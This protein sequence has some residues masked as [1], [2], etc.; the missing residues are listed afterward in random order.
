MNDVSSRSHAIFQLMLTQTRTQ[1][2][3]A[4]TIRMERA[5]KINLVDLAGSERSGD[6]NADDT[7]R[8]K[9]GNL[10]NL[11]L[12]TLR[13]VMST[14]AQNPGAKGKHI[15]YRESVLTWLLRESLGGNAKTLMVAAVSPADCNY[16]ET[17][18]TVRYASQ[19]KSIT[20]KAVVNEDAGTVIVR[21]LNE[22]I[23][24]LR[25]QLAQA[26]SAMLA[27]PPSHLTTST[28][29]SVEEDE[30][31][32]GES[33][34][35]K[36]SE[37]EKLVASYTQPWE[38][39]LAQSKA[40]HMARLD[41]LREHGIVLDGGEEDAVPVGVMA[42]RS[43]PYLMNLTVNPLANQCLVYYLR[44]GTTNVCERRAATDGAAPSSH[45]SSSRDITLDGAL[46]ADQQ[47][48]FLCAESDV[49]ASLVRLTVTDTGIAAVNGQHVVGQTALRSGDRVAIGRNIFRFQNPMEAVAEWDAPR[50]EDSAL[51]I[52]TSSPSAGGSRPAS[53]ALTTG[54]PSSSIAG[55]LQG[56]EEEE[57]VVVMT[58]P[59]ADEDECLFMAPSLS[60]LP[61][62][63]S[64]FSDPGPSSVVPVRRPVAQPTTAVVPSFVLP[65]SSFRLAP[66]GAEHNNDEVERLDTTYAFELHHHDAL[67]RHLVVDLPDRSFAMK[68]VP[69]YGI[70]FLLRHAARVHGVRPATAL[71][72]KAAELFRSTIARASTSRP[73]FAL[74]MLLANASELLA[75]LRMDDTLMGVAGSAQVLLTDCVQDAFGAILR[76][77]KARLRSDLATFLDPLPTAGPGSADR[78][79]A[80]ATP[81][82]RA[83]LDSLTAVHTALQRAMVPAAIVR[84]L[85]ASLF[86]LIGTHSF[87]QLMT[88][89]DRD[90]YRCD[91]GMQ[92]RFS[93]ALVVD[94]AADRRLRADDHLVHIIQVR[95]VIRTVVYGGR[96]RGGGAH[97]PVR[98]RRTYRRSRRAG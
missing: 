21:R 22:E 57:A 7:A 96:G 18:S 62:H 60:H 5:S 23:E 73:L 85:F 92:I 28:R 13:K 3:G 93:V 38:A 91:R 78:A 6:I 51:S 68:L 14:L 81:S 47:C 53:L 41:S 75:V 59:G 74:A 61:R 67:F 87:N 66:I 71:A 64:P 25:E 95:R 11:S 56:D 65:P 43:I 69:A 82:M 37:T 52:P 54:F 50:A 94:W 84:S 89:R 27:S 45:R 88:T 34:A 48:A 9:E 32:D 83:V 76:E 72:D 10:I 97:R 35:H 86:Y 49:A 29:S 42:P 90:A 36:L 40:L 8:L 70:Y 20:N 44:P 30:D 2:Q 39:R 31:D 17:M 98:D 4:E 55:R 1:S 33:L 15:P 79:V 63:P 26:R 16:E 12:S 19:A 24:Q 46:T 58:V 77:G 80:A